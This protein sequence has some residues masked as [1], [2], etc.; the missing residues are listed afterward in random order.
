MF[1]VFVSLSKVDSGDG[2]GGHTVGR[3]FA[4]PEDYRPKRTLNRLRPFASQMEALRRK[5]RIE[6]VSYLLSSIIETMG[7]REHFDAVSK[8]KDE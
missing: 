5:A 1:D 4:P 2:D 6:P 3:L 7:L 8:T